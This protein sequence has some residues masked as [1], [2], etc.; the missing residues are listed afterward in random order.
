RDPRFRAALDRWVVRPVAG[1]VVPVARR[2]RLVRVAGVDGGVVWPVERRDDDATVKSMIE[3]AAVEVAPIE[4]A[5]GPEPMVPLEAPARCVSRERPAVSGT[6][7]AV[8]R[9]GVAGRC[10]REHD[11]DTDE[12]DGRNLSQKHDIFTPYPFDA[13]R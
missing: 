10:G 9:G 1:A 11:R 2:R 13:Q 7:P 5:M 8:S 6:P 4:R 3:V 12:D